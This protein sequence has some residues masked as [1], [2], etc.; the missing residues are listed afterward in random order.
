MKKAIIILSII[1]FSLSTYAQTDDA[2]KERAAGE[3][4]R[5]IVA[6]I[7]AGIPQAGTADMYLSGRD[8]M[9]LRH[10]SSSCEIT[11]DYITVSPSIT[12][13]TLSIDKCKV[14]G[15]MIV[16]TNA[17]YYLKGSWEIEGEEAGDFTIQIIGCQEVKLSL[18]GKGKKYNQVYKLNSTAPVAAAIDKAK[19]TI[20]K[21]DGVVANAEDY[22][23][24]PEPTDNPNYNECCYS[25][26]F[27]GDLEPEGITCIASGKYLGLMDTRGRQVIPLSRRY[28]L[29]H[30]HFFDEQYYIVFTRDNKQGI[31][32][33][34]EP[35]CISNIYDKL[36]I[37]TYNYNGLVWGK[38]SRGVELIQL[39]NDKTQRAVSLT[40][41]RCSDC[42]AIINVGC[43]VKVKDKWGVLDLNGKLIIEPIYDEPLEFVDDAYMIAKKDGK[44]G[45]LKQD[46]SILLPF[47]YD[48]IYYQWAT[49]A[50]GFCLTFKGTYDGMDE[51]GDI[52]N[53]QGLWGTIYE[54]RVI[55]PCILPSRD[56][57]EEAGY[58]EFQ[59]AQDPDYIPE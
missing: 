30:K 37:A 53:A 39:T 25:A 42:R 5:T 21:L 44:Y 34:N 11:N 33:F 1:G 14:S 46:F 35:E 54:G 48:L 57:A 19:E 12:G 41:F 47:E 52:V 32:F 56:A 6:L 26:N 8:G 31:S 23:E 29:F 3:A 27:E 49:D 45:F 20:D 10:G 2:R 58:E 55:R 50:W 15:F 28:S 22:R 18:K 51:Y 24:L 59:K 36:E 4:Y 13:F 43:C 17:P 38:T 16:S 9:R 7:K 40:T